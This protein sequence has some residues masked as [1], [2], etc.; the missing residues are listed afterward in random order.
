M[1]AS[2]Y[3]R[4]CP[5][6][7]FCESAW[8]SPE[9]SW[10][11]ENFLHLTCMVMLLIFWVGC[12]SFFPYKCSKL[13]FFVCLVFFFFLFCFVL[14]LPHPCLGPVTLTRGSEEMKK[15]LPRAHVHWDLRVAG[16]G[17][18]AEAVV[19]WK[20][21]MFSLYSWTRRRGYCKQLN[22][23]AGLI[24]YSWTRRRALLHTAEPGGGAIAYSWTRRRG[25]C[26]QLNQEAGLIAYSWT[27]RKV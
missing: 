12:V 9:V 3:G 26:I 6:A 18:D 27:R 7:E 1:T 19:P 22:Q 17:S 10:L 2:S 4:F 21:S 11:E 8:V 25:Y 13:I 15:G 23:E 5:A 24:A 14:F 16:L 20:L